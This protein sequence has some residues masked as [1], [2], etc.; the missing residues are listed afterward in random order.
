MKYEKNAPEIVE[1]VGGLDNIRSVYHCVT[2]VRFDLVDNDKVNTAALQAVA[3]VMGTNIQG[4][5]FQ[6]IIGNDVARVFE[7]ITAAY[8][9]LKTSTETVTPADASAPGK[10]ANPL[11]K[12]L[13]FIAGVFAPILPAIAGAGLLKGFMALFVSLGWADNTTDTYAVL[14]AIS[15]GVFYF[16]PML[17]AVSAARRF[18][19]NMFIAMGVAGALLYPALITLMSSGDAV[20]FLGVPVTAVS[21]ASSVIPILL[22]VWLMSWV[23]KG[24]NKITPGAIKTLVVPLVTLIVVV[25]ITLVALGPLGSFVGEGMSGGIN[26]LLNNGGVFAGII[27]GG[28]LPLIIM[29]GMH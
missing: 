2:R 22:A 23:E 18:G 5:Q 20:D 26:W 29:T 4:R 1:A 10:K 16:L 27:I 11:T 28:L 12:L 14:T 21:Y 13:D 8:P 3:P 24:M 19:A 25:P 15:D 7:A 17:V 6:V 9:S